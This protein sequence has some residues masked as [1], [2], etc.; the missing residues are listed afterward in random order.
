MRLLHFGFQEII[1]DTSP[2]CIITLKLSQ[3]L[4]ETSP[5]I[6]DFWRM[7]LRIHFGTS[8]ALS[9]ILKKKAFLKNLFE[10]ELKYTAVGHSVWRQRKIRRYYFKQLSVW[11]LALYKV[12]MV[13]VHKIVLKPSGRAIPATHFLDCVSALLMIPTELLRSVSQLPAL[14]EISWALCTSPFSLRACGSCKS[15]LFSNSFSPS[16]KLPSF[17]QPGLLHRSVF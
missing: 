10:S 7:C 4:K 17:P 14:K 8:G 1:Y 15:D 3:D 6:S 12:M 9:Y 13:L 5:S 2:F 11:A 16:Q